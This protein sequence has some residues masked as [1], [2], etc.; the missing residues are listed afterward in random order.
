MPEI[1]KLLLINITAFHLCA[2]R[3][4]SIQVRRV[5]NGAILPQLICYYDFGQNIKPLFVAFGVL[6]IKWGINSTLLMEQFKD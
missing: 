3:Q 5:D 2:E 6:S 1:Y 4:E